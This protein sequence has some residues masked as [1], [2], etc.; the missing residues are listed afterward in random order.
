MLL[1]TAE[2][3]WQQ[4]IGKIK[5]AKTHIFFDTGILKAE[6]KNRSKLTVRSGLDRGKMSSNSLHR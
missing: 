1:F 6:K 2:S 5:K 3:A 4:D